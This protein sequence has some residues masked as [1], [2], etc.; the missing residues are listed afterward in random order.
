M[1]L[2]CCSSEHDT[3]LLPRAVA[4]GVLLTHRAVVATVA[5]LI[6]FL[7]QV[8]GNLGSGGGLGPHD[9]TLSYLPLAHI[10]DR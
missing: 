10:F 1:H 4:Q 5:A 7:E 2:T 6:A 3:H 9:S 8:K